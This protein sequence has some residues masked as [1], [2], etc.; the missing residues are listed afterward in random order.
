ML[1]LLSPRTL[2]LYDVTS[3]RQGRTVQYPFLQGGLS[4]S[5]SKLALLAGISVCLAGCGT[6][7]IPSH[8]RDRPIVIDGKNTEWQGLLQ[9]LGEKGTSVAVTNDSSFVYL[10]LATNNHDVQRLILRHGVTVWLDRKGGKEK[11]FGIHYPLGFGGFK[12]RSEDQPSEGTD[13]R[14]PTLSAGASDELEIL[15]GNDGQKSRM[16]M[17]QAS[18]IEIRYGIEHDTLVYEMKVPLFDNGRTPF[19]IGTQAGATIGAGIVA[20]AERGEGRPPAEGRQGGEGSPTGT[21]RHGGG[22]RQGGEPGRGRPNE[23][24]G[25]QSF[26]VWA[27]VRLSDGPA[28]KTSE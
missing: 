9:P 15:G 2:Q 27:T 21:G 28:A 10:A 4:Y 25:S 26:D 14:M 6:E 22:G 17:A 11:G 19:A 7:Q 16:T 12:P 5:L 18:G 20:Q 8:W 13:I 3:A 24:A 1:N 23:S